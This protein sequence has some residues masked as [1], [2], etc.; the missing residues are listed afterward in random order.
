MP[1]SPVELPVEQM[2][3]EY[4]S[5]SNV[6][7]LATKYRVGQARVRSILSEA[8]VL[9]SAG[10]SISAGWTRGDRKKS[11]WRRPGAVIDVDLVTRLHG[12]GMNPSDIAAQLNVAMKRVQ[13]ILSLHG[14]IP[15][16]G[17]HEC[18]ICKQ[19]VE[20]H[21]GREVCRV[22]VPEDFFT[23]WHKYGITRPEYDQMLEK[24]GGHCALCPEPATHLDHDHST[25]VNRGILC[26]TCNVSMAAVDRDIEWTARAR[27]YK[28]RY[29]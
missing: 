10:Q 13:A 1:N 21:A 14:L 4:K 12:A 24:Q 18:K 17:R 25:L 5:G 15:G 29:S 20:G 19:I 8:G 16:A 2:I 6:L 3:T 26:N 22:C 27:E 28:E 7:K 11:E 23:R 9:R